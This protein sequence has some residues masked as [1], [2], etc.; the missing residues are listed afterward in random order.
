MWVGDFV[1]SDEV[2][3]EGAEGIEGFATA[4]LAAACVFLPVACA[5]IVGTSIAIDKIEGVGGWNI[6]ASPTNDHGEFAFVVDAIA[7]EVAWQ[8]NGIFRI[9]ER[10]G[11]FYEKDWILGDRGVRLFG[12][13]A[14][15]NSDAE[16]LSGNEGGKDFA[17]RNLLLAGVKAVEG[18]ALE[19]AGS[20][21]G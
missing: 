12:V 4:P 14:V 3:T 9:L 17:Q 13:V 11:A 5:D 2:G 7:T 8:K 16:N 21:V 18:V 20:A 19:L 6:F 15:V 1:R 10:R